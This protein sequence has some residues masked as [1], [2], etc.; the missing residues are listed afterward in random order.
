[1]GISQYDGQTHTVIT[2]DLPL[3]SKAKE[4]VWANS[5]KFKNVIIM[6]GGLH[7]CF[8]FMRVIE[9]HM[10]CSGLED[11]WLEAGVFG[12]NTVTIVLE[13]KAYYRAVGGHILTYEALWWLKWQCFEKWLSDRH[14]DRPA[15]QEEL[16]D[17]QSAFSCSPKIHDDVQMACLNLSERLKETDTISP[18]EK[19][20]QQMINIK[21]IAFWHT[22][23]WLIE[24][25]LSFIKAQQTVDWL[26]HVEAFAAMLP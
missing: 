7:M 26:M 2:A 9:Q 8:N 19:F 5:E 22:Y 16:D 25:L 13:G 21:N 1:M 15:L 14:T 20:E 23:L 11:I 17:I 10:E 3:Y 18:L 6:M 12:A 24:I 4:L